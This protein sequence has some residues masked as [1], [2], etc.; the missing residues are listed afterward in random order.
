LGDC[1]WR[2]TADVFDAIANLAAIMRRHRH[3]G[4]FGGRDVRRAEMAEA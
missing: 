1:E 2:Q 4:D 3:R